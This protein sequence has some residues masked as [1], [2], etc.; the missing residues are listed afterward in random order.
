LLDPWRAD[1]GGGQFL[2]GK[3]HEVRSVPLAR[4]PGTGLGVAGRARAPLRPAER[5]AGW[6]G[7]GGG[8]LGEDLDEVAAQLPGAGQ[9]LVQAGRW[10]ARTSMGIWS[11]P[12]QRR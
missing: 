10:V 12:G 5:A 8:H 6:L 1:H 7:N 4:R 9:G 11:S 3:G 2:H